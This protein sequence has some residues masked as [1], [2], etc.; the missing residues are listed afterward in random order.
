MNPVLILTATGP[1]L[2]AIGYFSEVA[3]L[4]WTGV[5]V[6]AFTV[7]MNVASGVIKFP[8]IETGITVCAAIYFDPWFTGI[9]IGLLIAM[10]LDTVFE[11][12]GFRLEGRL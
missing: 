10:A 3:P 12:I 11:I 8:F 9:G 2:G 4:F 1:T 5:F 6:A 7:F